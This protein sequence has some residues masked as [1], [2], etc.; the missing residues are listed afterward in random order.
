M[1]CSMLTAPEFPA[2]KKATFTAIF[3][4]FPPSIHSNRAGH[5]L[6]ICEKSEDY[7]QD[8]AEDNESRVN[9]TQKQTENNNRNNVV[10]P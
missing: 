4:I 6:F 3:F 1:I 2:A 8:I 7:I 5:R 9:K 10:F